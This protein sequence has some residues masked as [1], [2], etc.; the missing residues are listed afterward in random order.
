MS[1]YDSLVI[2]VTLVGGF[3]L[4]LALAPAS[5]GAYWVAWVWV[6]SYPVAL[7]FHFHLARRC[8]PITPRG[9]FGALAGPALGVLVVVAV[10]AAGAQLRGAIGSPL[11]SLLFLVTLGLGTYLIFLHRVL[12]LRFA[13]LLPHRDPPPT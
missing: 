8:A 13:D 4:A 9:L 12:H 11:L 7:A 10:L 6:L 2:G 5:T 1:I 3:G